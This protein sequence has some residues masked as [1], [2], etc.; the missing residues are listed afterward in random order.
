M[1]ASASELVDV[2]DED[3]RVVRQATRGEVYA[4]G[5]IHRCAVAFVSDSGGRLFVHRRAATKAVF[6]SLYDMGVGGMVGAGE[7]YLDAAWREAGEELGAVGLPRPTHLFTFRYGRPPESWWIAVHELTWDGPVAPPAD[8]IAWWD[9]LPES[10]VD[11]RLAT[12]D[13]VPDGLEA[14]RR[15]RAHRHGRPYPP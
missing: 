3:D 4:R 6:P 2:V 10:G 7:S 8:E 11:S 13:W 1:E 14:Y 5:L 9:W 12:W 15:L